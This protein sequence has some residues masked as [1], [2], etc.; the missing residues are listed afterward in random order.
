M[1]FVLALV[2]GGGV[3]I[4]LGGREWWV[5]SGADSKPVEVDLAKLEAGEALPNNYIKI[6]EHWALLEAHV[7]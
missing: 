1:R 6:G 7:L 4:F 5:S 2:V 3:L